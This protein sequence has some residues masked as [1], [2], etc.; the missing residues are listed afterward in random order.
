[1]KEWLQTPIDGSAHG[2]QIDAMV[3]VVH[4]LMLL[5]FIGWGIYFIYVLVRFRKSKHPTADPVGTRSHFSRYVE[6]GVA[7]FE[8]I[9]LLGFSIPIWSN[10]VNAFPAEK[11]AVIIRVVA[12]Q[13]AWNIH[14]PGADGKFGRTNIYLVSADNPLGLDRND[15]DAKD[16]I[17]TI[18]QMNLP[19]GMPVIMYLT[20][21]DVIHC[22]NLPL[23]RVKHDVIPGQRI[24]LWF[25]PVKTTREIQEE[26]KQQI[27]IAD[28]KLSPALAMMVA[29]MDYNGKDGN[30]IMKKGDSF[31]EEL[32]PQL[33]QA[34]ITSVSAA[35]ETP[36]EIACAQLCGLGHYRMRGFMTVQ[37]GDEFNAWLAEQASYLTQ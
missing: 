15:P 37:T 36:T 27:S 7:I 9:L 1:M 23:Y 35:P 18:N 2:P 25:T 11:D 21:K 26:L 17:T 16:D 13:F 22:L 14:Y 32:I 24:P 30:P 6:I 31:S 34:G 3:A 33:L 28:G 12:E 10:I 19:V 4:W 8:A 5:L 29:M 20:S